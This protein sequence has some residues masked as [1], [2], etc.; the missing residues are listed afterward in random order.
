VTITAIHPLGIPVAEASM[1][2]EILYSDEA[3]AELRAFR[4]YDR[5][6]IIAAIEGILAVNPTLEGKAKVKRLKQ[7]APT[8]YRLRV[9]E[10]RIFYDVV[11]QT[12]LVIHVLSKETSIDY[13]RGQS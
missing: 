6:A 2:F 3:V 12:V 9:D 11:G 8:Q 13:L 5:K 10:F 4:I 1:A 7:P